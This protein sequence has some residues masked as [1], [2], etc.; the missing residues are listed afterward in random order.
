MPKQKNKNDP[1]F[2]YNMH[3]TSRRKCRCKTGPKTW[4][5]HWT[6]GTGLRLPDKCSAKY[7]RRYV[8]VGAHVRIEGEDGRTPWII[9]FCQ[10]HNKRAT[11]Y[12]IELKHGV[13]L[14][15]AAR[16]DCD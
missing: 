2:V 9:P 16:I 5:G 12:P 11:S 7:C 10:Y 8:E 15:G 13:T 6:R 14:C 1:T 3:K 4:V